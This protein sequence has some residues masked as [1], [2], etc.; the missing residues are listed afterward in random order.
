ME[1]FYTSNPKSKYLYGEEFKHCIKVFRKKKGEKINLTDGIGNLFHSKIIKINRNDCLIE[2]PKKIKTEKRDKIVQLVISP[3]K[4]MN[5][6]EWMIEKL[7]EIGINII[8]F[9]YTDNSERRKIKI[10]RIEKKAISAM[11]Q[12]KSLFKPKIEEIISLDS[13]L[14]KEVSIKNKYFADIQSNI[15]ISSSRNEDSIIIIGPEGDFRNDEKI[16]IKEKGFKGVSL[17][18]Q[19]YRTETAAI[20]SAFTLSN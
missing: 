20:L 9:I 17:G 13:F 1:L 8:S 6:N 11:K 16:K 3:T 19:I 4:S 5:R 15:K 14:K 18:N 2:K 10:D 7:S 12:S